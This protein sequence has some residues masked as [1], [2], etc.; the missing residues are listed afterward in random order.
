[1]DSPL[2]SM[3]VKSPSSDNAS[4]AVTISPGRQTNPLDRESRGFN[5]NDTRCGY[6][7]QAG[8]CG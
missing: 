7:D 2:G 6:P 4:S 8:E 5:G 1:M 3:T